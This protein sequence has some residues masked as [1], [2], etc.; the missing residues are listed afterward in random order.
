MTYIDTE[1][2]EQRPSQCVSDLEF[3][4]EFFYEEKKKTVIMEMRVSCCS[5]PDAQADIP[6]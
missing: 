4:L 2:W 6:F 3:E 1:R 5:C